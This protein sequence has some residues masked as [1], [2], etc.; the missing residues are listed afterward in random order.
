MTRLRIVIATL[1]LAALSAGCA[2]VNPRPDEAALGYTGGPIQGTH[3][4]DAFDPGS[5]LHWL[6]VLDEWFLYPTTVRTYIV[7]A[8]EGEGDRANVDRIPAST[9]DGIDAGW[10]LAINFKLNVS[11]LRKFHEQIGLTR[12]AYFVNDQPSDGWRAMLNDFFRQQIENSLQTVSR[13]Y[14]ADDIKR[15]T[16][17]FAKVNNEL[18]EILKDRINQSV[19][20]NFFCGPNFSGPVAADDTSVDCPPMQVVIK[21]A[22]LPDGVVK[23]YEAQK[24]AENSKVTA[25]NEGQAKIVAAQRDAEAAKARAAGQAAAQEQLAGIY[26]DPGYIEFLRVQA[27]QTCAANPPC[28]MGGNGVNLNVTK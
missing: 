1:V 7:S 13:R 11:R 6:G 23:S 27:M 28:L 16:D 25:E 24:V 17:T 5:G 22:T 18:A 26:R 12:K 14:S 4:K 10:E 8:A 15:G 2:S 9:R 20:G 21:A 19:G 3:F